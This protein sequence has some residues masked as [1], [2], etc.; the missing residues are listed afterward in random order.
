MRQ[1][2]EAVDARNLWTENDTAHLM[3]GC[4]MGFTAGDSVTNEYGRTWEIP[5][6]WICDGS[7]FPTG[8]G[9]NPSLTIMAVA[10]R[11]GDHIAAAARR[12]DLH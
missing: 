9:A 12:G 6:L 4:R 5:N 11:I 7:L 8:G 10:C 2:L 1:M 3:G